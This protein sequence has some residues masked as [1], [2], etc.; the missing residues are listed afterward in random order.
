MWSELV[1]VLQTRQI[2]IMMHH[3]KVLQMRK[4]TLIFRSIW[5]IFV[6]VKRNLIDQQKRGGRWNSTINWNS[7]K[8]SVLHWCKVSSMVFLKFVSIVLYVVIDFAQLFTYIFIWLGNSNG[9]QKWKKMLEM[10][11]NLEHLLESK[12]MERAQQAIVAVSGQ[13][14]LSKKKSAILC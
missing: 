13:V 2:I 5:W 14:T 8:S 10:V 11:K 6:V 9:E 3:S 4:I 1:I 12:S 7:I